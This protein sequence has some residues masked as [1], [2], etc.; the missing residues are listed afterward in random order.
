MTAVPT[1][2]TPDALTALADQHGAGVLRY[3]RSLVGDGDT[4]RDL[5]QET[6]LRLHGRAEGAGAPL[7]YTVARSC[8]ID[9]LRRR[10]VRRRAEVVDPAAR[11]AAAARHPAPVGRQP[12]REHENRRLRADLLAAL[13]LLPEDQRS[14]FHLSEIEG[15]PYAEIAAILAVSPGTIA[16]RKHHAVRKLRD[17]LRRRGHGA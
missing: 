17:E 12:D 10:R 8:A 7:V 5:L 6:F 9:H 1:L 13:A 11:E 14:V 16:S 15:L 4:A 3:L 2:P